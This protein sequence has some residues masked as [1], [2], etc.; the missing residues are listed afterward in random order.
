[1]SDI[2]IFSLFSIVST[3]SDPNVD[4][5]DNLRRYHPSPS[6]WFAPDHSN[7]PLV[8]V[9]ELRCMLAQLALHPTTA[10]LSL[11]QHHY[12]EIGGIRH[13]PLTRNLTASDWPGPDKNM[14]WVD[15]DKEDLV[16]KC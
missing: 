6:P 9:D 1:V 15:R 3:L 4:P 14:A 16:A 10:D 5:Y 8:E 11:A 7:Q 13:F 2:L 12:R